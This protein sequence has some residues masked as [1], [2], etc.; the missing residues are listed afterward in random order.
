MRGTKIY[1]RGEIEVLWHCR[2]CLLLSSFPGSR[3]KLLHCWGKSTI[4]DPAK[5]ALLGDQPAPAAGRDFCAFNF[6]DGSCLPLFVTQP[7]G[8][9]F[10]TLSLHRESHKASAEILRWSKFKASQGVSSTGN[11]LAETFIGG[12]ASGLTD[13]DV[14]AH[15]TSCS[16]RMKNSALTAPSSLPLI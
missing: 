16:L 13:M 15:G 10:G 8:C 11:P 12:Y 3:G 1:G 4:P 2:P 7:E 6:C 9:V 5:E 14:L